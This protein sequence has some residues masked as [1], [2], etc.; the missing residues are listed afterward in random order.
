M[1]LGGGDPITA[2]S[3]QRPSGVAFYSMEGIWNGTTLI[4]CWR[5]F[6]S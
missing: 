5:Q 3:A 2:N 1:K 4:S 6:Q